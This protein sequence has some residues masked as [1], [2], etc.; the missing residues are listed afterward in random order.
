M[1][2]HIVS[3]K[4]LHDDFSGAD[5]RHGPHCLGGVPRLSRTAECDHCYDHRGDQSNARRA[6]LH[7]RSLQLAIDLGDR[8]FGAFLDGNSV[9]ADF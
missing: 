8:C 3:S 9:C 1:S 5:G 2:E 7:A 6:L 4:R